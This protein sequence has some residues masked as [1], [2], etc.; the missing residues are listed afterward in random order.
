MMTVFFYSGITSYP[1]VSTEEKTISGFECMKAI[2][3]G[4]PMKRILNGS[5]NFT[6]NVA[7]ETLVLD[8]NFPSIK[9]GF[10]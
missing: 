1:G 4:C 8:Q 9:Q 6:V 10:S 5:I 3:G 7:G 2:M